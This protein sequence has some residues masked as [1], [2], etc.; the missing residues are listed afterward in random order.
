VQS[1]NGSLEILNEK[2]ALKYYYY[3][4]LKKIL[5]KLHFKINEEYGYYEKTDI[6]KGKELILVCSR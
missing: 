4:Q 2:L 5:Q 3:D 6:E 1:K